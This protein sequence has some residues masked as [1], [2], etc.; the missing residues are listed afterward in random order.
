MERDFLADL[1]ETANELLAIAEDQRSTTSL[2]VRI[3]E[4]YCRA[5]VASLGKLDYKISYSL[6]PSIARFGPIFSG[7]RIHVPLRTVVIIPSGI[8]ICSMRRSDIR[9]IA[10][11]ISADSM[12]RT[13]PIRITRFVRSMPTGT[14]SASKSIPRKSQCRH[15]RQNQY[16]FH[17]ISL[18][19]D[20]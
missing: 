15:R 20:Q 19:P 4:H 10:S 6:P 7:V 3:P 12:I 5:Y 17:A 14:T 8:R 11:R 13:P 18:L 1:I 2:Q 16:L 9:S